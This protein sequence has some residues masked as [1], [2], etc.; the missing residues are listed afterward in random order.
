MG[1]VEIPAEV[2]PNT[3]QNA[4][5][6]LQSCE[7]ADKV[8]LTPWQ[9]RKRRCM[10]KRSYQKGT[11]EKHGNN[12]RGKVYVDV[13][14][15]PDRRAK[16]ITIGMIDSMTKSQARREFGQVA[17]KMGINSPSY[18]IPSDSPL[19]SFDEVSQR[20]EE[21]ILSG[22]KPKT[23]STMQCELRK[24]LRPAFKTLSVEEITPALVSDWAVRWCRSGLGVK[25]VKNLVI[26]LNLILKYTGLPY[27]PAKSVTVS[28][29]TAGRRGSAVLHA[30]S[31]YQDRCRGKGL[32]QNVF[33]HGGGHWLAC[34]RIGGA[35][36]RNG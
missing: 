34:G 33:C 23:Q 7:R 30:R 31:G 5:D 8:P 4:D 15:S 36:H 14:G 12:W 3:N 6:A 25:S 19:Q 27:F 35:S 24:H 20:W 16:W 9:R 26:T 1:Q 22:K 28:L 29:P 21:N 17:E 2:L 11:V 13:V 18:E 10:S 32:V